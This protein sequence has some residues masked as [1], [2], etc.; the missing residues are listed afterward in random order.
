MIA[1]AVPLIANKVE[2]WKAWIRECMGPR[3]EEFEEFNERMG[4]T[5]HRAWL[6]QGPRGP[7]AV[8]VLDGPGAKDFMQKLAKSKESFDRWFGDHISE[9]HGI[10]FSKPNTMQAPELL[11][12]WYV[13]SCAEAG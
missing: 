7:L 3:K 13:P 5:T 12:D 1:M 9:F 4:L 10:D 11:L 8:V 6:E 2:A